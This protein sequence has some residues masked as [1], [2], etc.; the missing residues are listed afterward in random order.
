MARDS[1]SLHHRDRRKPRRQARAAPPAAR[2]LTRSVGRGERGALPLPPPCIELP[3][4]PDIFATLGLETMVRVVGGEGFAEGESVS[5]G[6]ALAR[7]VPE[8][9]RALE[10]DTARGLPVAEAVVLEEEDARRVPVEQALPLP[11]ECAR[12]APAE[13]ES[14]AVAG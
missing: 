6:G 1:G 9:L 13:D 10:A 11:L 4:S 14:V 2:P 8:A 7:G 3:P 5:E 12:A